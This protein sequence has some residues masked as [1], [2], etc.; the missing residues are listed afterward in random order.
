V[1]IWTARLVRRA[2]PKRTLPKVSCA[3]SWADNIVAVLMAC[4]LSAASIA[5]F[6]SLSLPSFSLLDCNL[7]GK[8]RRLPSRAHCYPSAMPLPNRFRDSALGI[9]SALHTRN[10]IPSGVYISSMFFEEIRSDVELNT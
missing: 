8:S 7:V 4:S 6:S 10:I 2:S 3:P 9:S 5:S 1:A